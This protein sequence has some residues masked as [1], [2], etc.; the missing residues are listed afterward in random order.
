MSTWQAVQAVIEPEYRR[1]HASLEDVCGAQRCVLGE[2]LQANRS[3]AFGLHYDFAALADPDAY[4]A[5]VPLHHYEDLATDIGHMTTEESHRL[6]GE[7]VCSFEETSGTTTAAKLIPYT[8]STLLAF[9]RALYPWLA[10][11]LQ[12]RP[13][14]CKGRWY[15]AISPARPPRCTPTGIRIGTAEDTYYFGEVLAHH[16]ARWSAVPPT[17]AGVREIE[18]WRYATLRYLIAAADLTLIS[19]WSPTFLSPLLD[20]LAE[21]ASDFV[22]DIADGTV[23]VKRP[24]AASWANEMPTPDRERAAVLERALNGSNVDTRL[25]WPALDTISCWTDAGARRFVGPLREAFPHAWVQ[26][27]GLL[28]TEGVVSIPLIPWP[29]PVLAVNSAFFEFLDDQECSRLA[30]EL[31]EGEVYRVVMTTYGGLYRYDTRDVVLV[32]GWAGSAPMLEFVGRA[33][34]VSDLC[35]EKLTESF[36]A[37]RL[38]TQVGFAMLAPALHP[39]RHYTLFLDG[40]QVDSESARTLAQEVDRAL[41]ANPQYAY[42]RRLRQLG[43]VRA[44]RV[45]RPMDTFTEFASANGQHLGDIKPPVLRTEPDLRDRF[46][47]I[48]DVRRDGRARRAAER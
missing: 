30:H 46:V 5:C 37:E 34:V 9:R 39:A 12:G 14:L 42:A 31:R 10:D 6:C 4:R 45:Q 8:A 13:D 20:S 40:S 25:L 3:T 29:Y 21:R 38:P 2:I 48:D 22:R 23:S 43:R 24:A 33:G 27:K 1:F 16:F 28:A 41:A 19:V 17:V 11:L 36:V 44:C 35:G 47:S 15:W 26:G 7:P 32:R 18:V